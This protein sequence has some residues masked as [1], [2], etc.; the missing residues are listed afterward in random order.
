VSVAGGTEPRWRR[1]G[2]ELYFLG[3]DG[4][5]MAVDVEYTPTLRFGVPKVLF[6]TR[7]S[8]LAGP[9]R[10]YG[11]S[12]DGQRFL[13]NVPVGTDAVAP[14]TVILNWAAGLKK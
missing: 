11:V 13:M 4:Q 8:L 5:M 7:L 1:D 9:S 2:R 10:R 3:A 14:I 12:A 6:E